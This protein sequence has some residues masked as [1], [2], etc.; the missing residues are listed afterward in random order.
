MTSVLIGIGIYVAM[1]SIYVLAVTVI[2]H[3]L[4]NPHSKRK[5][6]DDEDD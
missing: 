4:L 3:R 1:I 6:D 2:I 5:E